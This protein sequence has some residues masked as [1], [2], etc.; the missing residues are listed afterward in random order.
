MAGLE[1]LRQVQQVAGGRFSAAGIPLDFGQDAAGRQALETGSALVDRSHWGRLRVTG[2]DRIRYLHNQS[3]NDFQ[4]LQPGQ[5]CETVMVT[6]T[7]RTLD[8]VTAYVQA[9]AILLLTS[10]Q[11][12]D[13]LASWLNKFIFFADRVEVADI[14]APTVS[15]TLVGPA[16]RDL[17]MGL[18]DQ[19][20]VDLE[21]H[22][23]QTVDWQGYPLIVAVGSGL[24][25]PGYT[26]LAPV[27]AAAP[28]WE[29]LVQAGAVPVG[30]TLWEEWR[31]S[32]GRPAP[33]R[34]LTEDYNPYEAGLWHCVS[35]NK[36]C[37]IGQE[38]LAR[39]N[40]YKG[41]KQQL[42]GLALTGPA[43]PGTPITVDGEKVGVLTS[44]GE[45]PAGHRGLGYVR[46]RAGGA[47]L[48]VQ[49]GERPAVVEER[50]LLS[51]G[52]LD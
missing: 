26:I 35:L 50:P 46:V 15:F 11:R 34:E 41:V 40:T 16:G 32:H 39:L 9:D 45:T 12:R 19:V 10:P 8:L 29:T 25:A 7:A 44:Y 21:L 17:V 48:Q 51:R 1:T 13:F 6:S 42:W 37:Y 30:E 52:Y 2:D 36:G 20:P 5:G 33:D 49:V 28:L 3:T 18:S 38:T 22:G 47:G 14:S 24:A 23:H 43:E 27:E 31:L 4:A